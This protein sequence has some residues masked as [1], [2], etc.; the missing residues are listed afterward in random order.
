MVQKTKNCLKKKD[1]SS[2]LETSGFCDPNSA[3][4]NEEGEHS[5]S[6]VKLQEKENELLPNDN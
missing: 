1:P 5:F 3:Q 6:S 4:Q 2:N